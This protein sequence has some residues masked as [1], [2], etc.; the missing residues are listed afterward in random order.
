MEEK[1]AAFLFSRIHNPREI[2]GYF[3]EVVPVDLNLTPEKI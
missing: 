2:I 1:A 3:N